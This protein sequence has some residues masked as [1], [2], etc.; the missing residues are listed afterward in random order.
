MKFSKLFLW[1]VLTLLKK[2]P[3]YQHIYLGQMPGKVNWCNCLNP[4]H[5][6]HT[7][8]TLINKAFKTNINICAKRTDK[9]LKF[10]YAWYRFMYMCRLFHWPMDVH[11]T[12]L[13]TC[14]HHVARGE[15][16]SL[17]QRSFLLQGHFVRHC[18]PGLTS[19]GFLTHYIKICTDSFR[20]LPGQ[21]NPD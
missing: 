21:M 4:P 13:G 6:D 3:Y 15:A 2:V 10:P 8:T 17:L 9:K 18:Q 19:L 16:T 1:L 11:K 20:F 12:S 5:P 14:H 7:H